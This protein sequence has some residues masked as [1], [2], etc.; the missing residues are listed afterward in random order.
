MRHK[1]FVWFAAVFAWLCLSDAPVFAQPSENVALQLK[2]LHSF[3]FAGYYAA[4]EQGYYAEAGL[5][6]AIRERIPGVNNIEQVLKGEAQYGVADT[7]L[8]L[9]R[10]KGKPLI[11]LASIFQHNPLVYITLKQSGI[12]SPY[13]L[14]GKRVMSDPI[15]DAP[16]VAML[17]ET[18][19]TP[20]KFT[21]LD[22]SFNAHDLIDGK[23]DAVS[24]YITDQV[25]YFKQQGVE[26]N[27]IDPRNYGV[28]FLGD[29]LFTTEKELREHPERV[30]L[31]R[32]ASLRGWEYAL[33]HPEAM[34][35][36]ILAKYNPAKRLSA[37]H[38]RFEARETA[39]MILPQAI[40]VGSTDIKR[41]ER[42][43]QTYQRLGLTTGTG[44]AL[45]GFI[46]GQAS[47]GDLQLSAEEKAWLAAHPSIR[48]GID[49]DFAPYEWVD[50]RGEY[51]GLAAD[52]LALLGQRLRVSFDIVK[53]KSWAEML[54]MAQRGEIDMIACVVKTPE[55]EKYLIFTEPY[56]STPTVILD[57]GRSGFIGTLQRLAGKRVAV[58]RGYFIEEL[59][60][61]DYPDISRVSA[62]DVHD[63]LRLVSIGSADAYIGDAASAN[64]AVK[65]GGLLNLRLSGQTEYQSRHSMAA[66][67]ANPELAGI[68]AKA[69]A[70]MP[71]AE[72]DDIQ[73][74]WMS[75]QAVAGV[76]LETVAKYIAG[77]AVLLLLVGYWNFRLRREIVERKVIEHELLLRS[78]ELECAKVAAE[79]A[80]VVKSRFLANMSHEIR[81]PMNAI[82]GFSEL[83]RGVTAENEA[84]S[85]FQHI[86]TAANNL[87]SIIND[88]LDF[89]KVEAG[90]M[91]LEAT[92]FVLSDVVDGAVGLMKAKAGEKGL[93]LTATIAEAARGR[94][95]GDALR[96]NQILINLLSNAVK[97]TVQ[98]CV[99][100]R[101]ERQD[102]EEIS[103]YAWLRFSVSDTGI[104][105]QAGDGDKLFQPF[106]QAD[107]S[108]TRKYGGTGLGLTICRQ[109]I[110]LMGGDIR[111]ESTPGS[112]SCFIF[113]V[114]LGLPGDIPPAQ[115]AAP[116]TQA[117]SL[118][119]RTVLLVD[120]NPVNLLVAEK[121]LKN[122]AL[123]VRTAGNGLEALAALNE[124]GYDLVLMDV[125]MPE[126]DGMEATRRIRGDQ[127]WRDL[128]VIAMT[129]HALPD[130]V[131]ACLAQGMNDHIA[132][133]IRADGLR[134][135]L[136]KW[137]G[138]EPS[139]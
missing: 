129:A 96:I 93:S 27:I 50:A 38:L 70:A 101:V 62:H 11:L 75:L 34:I 60:L 73:N 68:L 16:L 89:S 107:A 117:Q 53:D 76:S 124:G 80:S 78:R 136:Y 26:I 84:Q 37:E 51:V 88:I 35:R 71:R 45:D 121:L 66:T 39:K 137:L 42:M 10:L 69:L 54:A 36:L 18:G 25:D 91:R 82:I 103:D 29:N 47:S 122:L 130:E 49:R 131:T 106:S 22:N 56:A 113:T 116:A 109:L 64:Y 14:I 52:Y 86:Y 77:V 128:P 94:F 33:S 110:Q 4:I 61:R 58:E 81:T 92:P 5:N 59:L 28:D 13:E 12:V 15:D 105:I 98:G 134:Q 119:G 6:V 111:V 118:R 99:E 102:K 40:P 138:G 20:D 24:A 139:V 30:R 43:V 108:I 135:M 48:V 7:A 57:D 46:Y 126:M 127:R 125:Q 21:R 90:E 115:P 87:L 63:A 17:Y 23:T 2:W 74:R 67:R 41:F 1:L 132:K 104:G 55:R 97:F 9:D 31:F 114:Q 32:L 65:Q 112:G 100:V 120:D 123:E 44:K 72:M 83:G 8:L 95:L 133:P 85:Y 3:Q 19:I 79:Q